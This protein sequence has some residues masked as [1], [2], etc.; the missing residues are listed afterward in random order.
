[1]TT[2][3][4]PTHVSLYWL[5]VYDPETGSA[6][7][8][9]GSLAVAGE[10]FEE[11]LNP[12]NSADPWRDRTRTKAREFFEDANAQTRGVIDAVVAL[13]SVAESY[14]LTQLAALSNLA[15]IGHGAT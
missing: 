10:E 8:V 7:K 2:T 6:T 14:T 5:S 15:A 13:G 4:K 1:M 9:V 11:L 12:T 3:T